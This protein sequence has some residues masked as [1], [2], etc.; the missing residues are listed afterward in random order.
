MEKFV[1]NHTSKSEIIN[2]IKN[3]GL[4]GKGGAGFFKPGLKWS[5]IPLQSGPKIFSL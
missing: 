2:K 4:R 1:S 3:S 5:F